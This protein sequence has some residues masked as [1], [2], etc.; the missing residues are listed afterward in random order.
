MIAAAL[1]ALLAVP[2]AARARASARPPSVEKTLARVTALVAREKDEDA[3]TIAAL[4]RRAQALFR[5]VAPHGWRA[6]APLGAA[7]LDARRPE[8]VR[9]FALV[10]LGRLGDPAGFPALA[11]ILSDPAQPEDLR[12]AAVQSLEA[13]DLPPEAE[14][15]VLCGALVPGVRRT[16]A[17]ELLIP[18][19]RLGCPDP[20][21]LAAYAR[22]FG[23]RPKERAL[24]DARAAIEALGASRGEAPARALLALIAYYPPDGPARAAAIAAL[25]RK[26]D[27]VAALE[28]EA[29][30][31]LSEALRSQ[32]GDPASM[33]VLVRL[34]AP[35]GRDAEPL[36]LPLASYPDA[37]VL[38]DAADQLAR[39]KCVEALPKLEAVIAGAFDDPRFAPKPGRPD[40]AQLLA[41]IEAAA[42]SLKRARGERR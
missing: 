32:S 24:D 36:L 35:F 3:G 31:V 2:A 7:A 38:A 6:A 29:L 9:L 17:E 42:D 15:R 27:A 8:K 23:A 16:L 26:A 20:A 33:I 14:R 12:E 19:K 11:K 34:V 41:R 5:D 1:A 22:S 40:P 37:E 39:L 10:F 28:P 13:L 4:D 21:P 30:P 18:L 25:G